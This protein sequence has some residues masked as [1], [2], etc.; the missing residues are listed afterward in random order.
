MGGFARRLAGSPAV[1]GRTIQLVRKNYQIV[2]V[3]P[4]RYRWREADIYVPLGLKFEPNIYYG[5]TLR[6]RAGLTPEQLPL[7][8]TG[9]ML[10]RSLRARYRD[11]LLDGELREDP[12][13]EFPPEARPVRRHAALPA[14]A[15]PRTPS[16]SDVAT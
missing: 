12:L 7:G 8:L 16:V 6:I 9:K 4:P 5:A 2:G 15:L 1:V 14:E 13:A 11:C 10:K 3:M